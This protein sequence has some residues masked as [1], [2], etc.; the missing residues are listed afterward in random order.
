[1]FSARQK[2]GPRGSRYMNVVVHIPNQCPVVCWVEE[3]VIWMSIQVKIRCGHHFSARQKSGPERGADKNV[4]IK[5]HYA[6]SLCAG[7]VHEIIWVAA[8]VELGGRNQIPTAWSRCRCGSFSPQIQNRIA[9]ERWSEAD[10]CAS[11]YGWARGLCP[12]CR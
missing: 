5:V 1:H 9:A 6:R 11:I 2:G 3:E 12:R 10:R 7:I 4:I 8:A